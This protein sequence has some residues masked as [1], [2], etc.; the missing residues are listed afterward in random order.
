MPSFLR[1]IKAPESFPREANLTSRILW[2]IA[3]A[4]SF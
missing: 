2:T 4:Y 3:L 1:H